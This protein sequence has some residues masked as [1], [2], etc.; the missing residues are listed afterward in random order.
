MRILSPAAVP[1][2]S[3]GPNRKLLLALATLASLGMAVA[4]AVTTDGSDRRVAGPATATRHVAAAVETTTAASEV[5]PHAAP[6]NPALAAPTQHPLRLPTFG[7]LPNVGADRMPATPD[8][9]NASDAAL[10]R[11]AF[12]SAFSPFVEGV[13]RLTRD[14]TIVHP[15]RP[16]ILA[17]TSLSAGAG[18]STVASGFAH[19]FRRNGERTLLIDATLGRS[20][21]ASNQPVNLVQA[22]QAKLPLE[23]AINRNGAGV[24]TIFSG[25]G[26]A[27]DLLPAF[28]SLQM[29][30]MLQR[31]R[32]LYAV[33]VIDTGLP[34]MDAQ[35]QRF[36]ALAD[37]A[38]L[39]VGAAESSKLLE[40]PVFDALQA[41][42][43]KFDGMIINKVDLD[44]YQT[45]RLRDQAGI[46][47]PVPAPG[48][49]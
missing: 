25:A 11:F 4:F 22:F 15:G 45:R 31:L 35:T 46:A 49:G 44:I 27:D 20:A 30:A 17:F 33:I 19:A 9:G 40:Q 42:L 6:P 48:A 32:R 10:A 5:L 23:S 2:I 16:H 38:L 39:V 29:N 34:V 3:A 28:D 24:D 18:V 36:L 26:G 47:P 14:F 13:A 7:L 21:D 41:R 12:Q 8:A 37:S 1:L 43:G